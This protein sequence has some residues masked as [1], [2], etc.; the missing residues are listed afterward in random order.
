MEGVTGALTPI[1]R[2]RGEDSLSFFAAIS[3]APDGHVF[4]RSNSEVEGELL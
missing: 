2:F 1:S 4:D 3:Q